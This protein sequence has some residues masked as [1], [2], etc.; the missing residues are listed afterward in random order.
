[1]RRSFGPRDGLAGASGRSQCRARLRRR[2]ASLAI[3]VLVQIYLGALVAGLD[4]GLVFNTWPQ[5]DGAF[6]PVGRAAVVR[7]A[8]V[9]KPV[10][11]HADGAVQSPHG[12]RMRCGSWRRFTSSMSFAHRCGGAVL[13]GA[14]VLASAVT[15]QAVLG[16]VTLLHQAPLSLALAHQVMAIVVLT[17][18]VV[19]AERLAPQH[20]GAV[21]AG[22][23][24]ASLPRGTP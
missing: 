9:A 3:L 14:L 10:R 13:N 21:A 15:L 16:I 22:P 4:A 6:D 11:E 24:G 1:M 19:H 17:I 8:G 7:D 2:R 20:A 23:L 5:I 18:A 12:W